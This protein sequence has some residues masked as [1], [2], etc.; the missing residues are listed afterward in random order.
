MSLPPT[1]GEDWFRYGFHPPGCP[2]IS[3]ANVESVGKQL[4][5]D[6][7]QSRQP[8]KKPTSP[9]TRNA[10]IFRDE[11]ERKTSTVGSGSNSANN[12]D[13]AR[14]R[15]HG[16]HESN[17]EDKTRWMET[18]EEGEVESSCLTGKNSSSNEPFGPKRR[19]GKRRRGGSGKR[20]E[21]QTA[22]ISARLGEERG[23]IIEQGDADV[24]GSKA[25]PGQWKSKRSAKRN[26][27]NRRRRLRQL[28]DKENAKKLENERMEVAEEPESRGRRR[29]G[30]ADGEIL[31]GH[32]EQGRGRYEY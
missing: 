1:P 25:W 27:R 23:E 9:P 6:I 24:S 31:R 11:R 7:R 32:Q 4:I 16:T 15:A 18:L 30:D 20:Y 14:S 26:A 2:P 8:V 29:R 17:P 5:H 22:H 21:E 3:A 19:G 28:I 12:S 13:V 10:L